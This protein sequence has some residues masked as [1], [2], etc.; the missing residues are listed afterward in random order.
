MK[1][2]EVSRAG[3]CDG[4]V[5]EA[6]GQPK[7]SVVIPAYNNKNYIGRTIRSVL[8]QTLSDLEIVVVDDASSDG[9]YEMLAEEYA[10]EER[11]RLFRNEKNLGMTGNWNRCVELARAPFVKLL[12]ADDLLLPQALEKEAKAL[13][14]HPDCV[15][16]VSDT[17]LIDEED[18]I[19]GHF[20]RLGGAGEKD[21]RKYARTSLIWNN[22]FGAPLN[23]TF[24]KEAFLAAGGFDPD[25]PFIL[26]FDGWLSLAEHGRIY[27]I[28]EVLNEFRVRQDS[29]TGQAIV[30]GE[31]KKSYTAEHARLV[32]KHRAALGLGPVSAAFSKWWRGTRSG[33]I[34]LYLKLRSLS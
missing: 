5:R 23:V 15:M 4:A 9:T 7:V 8:E 12:C 32:D 2:M 21:G 17:A 3:E 13:E 10:G 14:D 30:T 16:A 6:K 1:E 24:R 11:V 25:F 22:F 19:K 31:K 26:D 29:N 34:A 33:L 18:R 27:V 28:R 20:T